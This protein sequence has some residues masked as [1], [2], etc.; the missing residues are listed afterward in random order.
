[1]NGHIHSYERSFPVYNNTLD[2]CG[3]VHLVLG[4]AGNYENT[5]IPWLF[6]KASWSAFREA[7]FGVASLTFIT[8]TQANYV[9]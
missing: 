7:S 6:P 1:M 8:D 4:D 3:I 5:Y 9:W 2:P